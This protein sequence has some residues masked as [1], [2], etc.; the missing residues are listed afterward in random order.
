MCNYVFLFLKLFIEKTPNL[1][2]NNADCSDALWDALCEPCS[3]YTLSSLKI[4]QN[5]NVL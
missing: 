4:V 3:K 1:S 2:I 5:C